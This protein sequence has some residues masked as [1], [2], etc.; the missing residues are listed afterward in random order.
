MK[1]Y[2]KLSEVY[3]DIFPVN[4]DTVSFLTEGLPSGGHI[5]DIAC[6]T[7]G[8]A[9]ALA[10]LGYVVH[11]LDLDEGMIRQARGRADTNVHWLHGDMTRIREYYAPDPFDLI[12]CIGNSIVH[13]DQKQDVLQVIS[14]CRKLLKPQGRLVIGV[15]N[16]NKIIS[17]SIR[18]LPTLDRK[19]AGIS[20][21]RHYRL[22]NTNNKI[23]FET[24]LVEHAG[25]KEMYYDSSVP[26]LPLYE[27]ELTA[28]ASQAGFSKV[29]LFGGFLK[30][31]YQPLQSA[32]VILEAY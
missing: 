26:L 32:S 10:D 1:F 29:S 31:A 22:D 14:D 3:D 6:A 8:Y 16:Y 17:N 21:V 19:E 13:L 4:P 20:F 27:E 12:Y 2:E 15:V 28:M 5:L 25:G 9:S 30:Q 18:S 7:G 23:L 24:R 11:A